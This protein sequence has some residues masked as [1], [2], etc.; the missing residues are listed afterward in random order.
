MM[1]HAFR[2]FF[3]QGG[4][5]YAPP[6]PNPLLV[7]K[8]QAPLDSQMFFVLQS[9]YGYGVFFK[10]LLKGKIKFAFLKNIDVRAILKCPLKFKK[11]YLV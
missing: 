10:L 3:S 1:M 8:G 6:P 7:P 4:G 5:S 2:F 11:F 9:S